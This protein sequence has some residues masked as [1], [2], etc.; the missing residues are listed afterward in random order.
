MQYNEK[1]VET[2]T[3]KHCDSEFEI[4][5]K[6][7]EFY[8]KVSPIFPLKET[9]LFRRPVSNNELI[10]DLWNWK[11]KY[12][13]PS[14]TLC[15]NC[16]NQRRL[17]W[18]NE[19]NL[20]KRKCDKTWKEIISMFPPNNWLVV[21][22]KDIINNDN[23]DALLFWQ[24][25][26]IEKSFFDQ[27][28]SLLQI[29]PLPNLT[30][31]FESENSEYQIYSWKMKNCY[32]LFACWTCEYSMYS[33]RQIRTN[34]VLDCLD[35]TDLERCYQLINSENCYSCYY[36]INWNGCKN[37]YFSYDLENCNDCIL[38]YNLS[39]KK[40]C[41]NNK[42]YSKEEYLRK[43]GNIKKE[44]ISLWWKFIDEMM[45]KSI[46]KNLMMINCE[47]S[48][49]D[50]LKNCNNCVNC[51]HFENAKNC[52]YIENWWMWCFN[53]Y[54]WRWIWANL[55]LWYEILDSWINSTKIWFLISSYGCNNWL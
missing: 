43:I 13:I 32:M 27:F 48:I 1:P 18:R 22:D 47:N 21:Y 14:P 51:F 55:D 8:E 31:T 40:Y 46:N 5:D 39:W 38:C 2:K 34:Y 15:P 35:W 20:Y 42:Q 16:R 37:C 33:S 6:Y 29:T 36:L 12:L 50:N 44:N 17:S 26:E 28:K 54:D 4:T 49:W 25:L 53:S 3:C 30:N 41:I 23:F 24:E 19:W 52:K 45:R 7:L 10:K 11:I 9:G